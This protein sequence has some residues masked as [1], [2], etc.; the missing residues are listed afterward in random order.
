[1]IAIVTRPL[2]ME[3]D[4]LVRDAALY[5]ASR[6]VFG[7]GKRPEACLVMAIRRGIEDETSLTPL[8]TEQRYELAGW[9]PGGVDLSVDLP[10][11]Q[12]RVSME[13]KFDHPDEAIWDAIKL[14]DIAASNPAS[15][16]AASYLIYVA[17]ADIWKDEP[18]TKLFA[19]RKDWGGRAIERWPS[20][21]L[22]LLKG[23]RGLRPTRTVSQLRVTPLP[24]E[25]LAVHPDY[26]IRILRVEPSYEAIDQ[27][28]D[29]D[30]WPMGYEPPPGMREEGRRADQM[31][32][33]GIDPNV[34]RDPC[35]GYPWYSKWSRARLKA[36]VPDL[37]DEAYECLRQRLARERQWTEEAGDL[38]WVD[39]LRHA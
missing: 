36:V 29:R 13:M 32:Q 1:M 22:G 14:A 17:E 24:M 5:A 28:Y 31:R 34:E 6:Q 26:W 7:C 18:V 15:P 30:G 21:W 35:H 12:G 39:S 33:T 20:A 27:E 25:R 37:D 10:D 11:D 9:H 16:I 38:P 8:P 3:P 2:N 4:D 19:D 23:G